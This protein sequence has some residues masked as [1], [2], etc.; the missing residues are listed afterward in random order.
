M[1]HARRIDALLERMREDELRLI[2]LFD[3]DNIRYFTGFRLNRVVTSVLAISLEEG[4]TYF[5]AKLDLNRAKRDVWIER[6]IPF[7]EDTPNYLDALRPLFG[8]SGKRIGVEKDSLTLAQAEYLRGFSSG[9]SEFVDV[10]AITSELRAIKSDEE[11]LSLRRAAEIASNA[12][13][14]VQGAIR[15]GIRE[16][17]LSAWA[18]YL[19]GKEGAEGSSFEPFLMSGENAWLPQ[20]ISS[21]KLLAEGE[22][23]LLDMGAIYDGYCSDTTRTFAIGKISSEQERIFRV[24]RKAQQAGIEAIRPGVRA[25]DVDAAARTVIE[26]A[27]FGEYFP[28]LTGHGI[29]ISSH[30]VPIAD[31]GVE[32]ILQPRMVL[33]V[34]PG[35]YLPGVGAARV[36]DMVVVTDSGC[37]LLTSAPRGL[38][39]EKE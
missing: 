15:P 35:I 26:D 16:A 36:E 22:L 30:E 7:S 23:G 31:R 14:L 32:T 1:E 18:E 12:M 9:K 29:G 17:E 4:P 13:G 11:I 27:G 8:N 37:E 39:G 28:H 3:R 34:E 24:A 10:R 21:Q 33:T 2:L 5:V 19:M 20:R 25:C 6:V 38:T